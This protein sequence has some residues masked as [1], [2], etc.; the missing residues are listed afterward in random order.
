M[1]ALM[2]TIESSPAATLAS[3]TIIRS[4]KPIRRLCSSYS[5]RVILSNGDEGHTNYV[6]VCVGWCWADGV[7]LRLRCESADVVRLEELDRVVEEIDCRLSLSRE[8]S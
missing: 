7:K 6:F 2:L 1:D 5:P 3:R 8:D 4:Y